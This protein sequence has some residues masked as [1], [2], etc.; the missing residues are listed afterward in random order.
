MKHLSGPCGVD[1]PGQQVHCIKLCAAIGAGDGKCGILRKADLERKNL[2]LDGCCVFRIVEQ[3][4]SARQGKIV[5]RSGDADAPFQRAFAPKVLHGR[6]RAG[7]QDLDHRITLAI[8][9]RMLSPG[10]SKAGGLS[11]G[12]KNRMV[13]LPMVFQPLG[14]GEAETPVWLPPIETAPAGILRAGVFRRGVAIR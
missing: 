13:V 7:G 1:P 10:P 6:E 14:P 9:K 11:A 12:S 5:H 4:I 3:N 8:L 2:N